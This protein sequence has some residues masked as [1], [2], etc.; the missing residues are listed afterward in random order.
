MAWS[1]ERRFAEAVLEQAIGSI[2]V[3]SG[4]PDQVSRWADG[5]RTTLIRQLESSAFR[6]TIEFKLRQII[7]DEKAGMG[8]S[9][10]TR[11][12]VQRFLEAVATQA[13]D[14]TGS[15]KQTAEKWK[16]GKLKDGTWATVVNQPQVGNW[17]VRL[18]AEMTDALRS[19]IQMG[20]IGTPS[21]NWGMPLL[22]TQKLGNESFFWVVLVGGLMLMVALLYFIFK[23]SRSVMLLV[24]TIVLAIILSV[25]LIILGTQTWG[26]KIATV[27]A[28]G[29]TALDYGSKIDKATPVASVSSCL[30]KYPAPPSSPSRVVYNMLFECVDPGDPGLYFTPRNN[31]GNY[32]A[33]HFLEARAFAEISQEAIFYVGV[34]GIMGLSLIGAI[35]WFLKGRTAATK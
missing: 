31:A 34:G 8:V 21:Q 5:I 24:I 35:I 29:K 33:V 25:T 11:D 28:D 2:T 14:Q 7:V 32:G 18:L 27:N 1:I 19:D 3:I 6:E 16:L 17:E 9:V 13:H 12:D 10:S 30:K 23:G 20:A 15:L 26:V 4:T 22:T